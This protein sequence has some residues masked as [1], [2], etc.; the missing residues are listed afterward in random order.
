MY[1]LNKKKIDDRKL[2]KKNIV[3]YFKIIYRKDDKKI[4]K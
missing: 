1:N 4:N 3:D 2:L